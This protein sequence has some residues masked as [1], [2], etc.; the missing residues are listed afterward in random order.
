M[1]L[2]QCF[3]CGVVVVFLVM[4]RTMLCFLSNILRLIKYPTTPP[5]HFV[6][7]EKVKLSLC[8]T[9]HYVMKAYGSTFSEVDTSLRW[10]VSLTPL[11]LNPLGRA[12]VTHWI[13]GWVGRRAG[14]NDMEKRILD[15]AATRT[16]PPQPPSPWPA[17]IP[18]ALHILC[19]VMERVSVLSSDVSHS[20]YYC[21]G[22]EWCSVRPDTSATCRAAELEMGSGRGLLRGKRKFSQESRPKCHFVHHKSRV[23]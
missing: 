9:K 12:P 17:A 14:M 6:S 5:V 23:A 21:F 1:R 2:L 3:G 20:L 19:K 11:P 18:T 7:K 10:M 4:N 15:P 13:G 22:V 8:W 16:P